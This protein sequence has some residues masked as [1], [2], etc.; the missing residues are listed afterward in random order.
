MS[1]NFPLTFLLQVKNEMAS[2]LS[3]ATSQMK[4]MGEAA[5]SS[6]ASVKQSGI[7]IGA[8]LS[9]ITMNLVNTANQIIGLKRQWEDLTRMQNNVVQSDNSLLNAKGKLKIAT[10]NLAQAQAGKGKASAIDLDIAHRSLTA[11][12]NKYGKGSI[13]AE[14]AQSALNKTQ[15]KGG[16]DADTITKK[17][18][19][20]DRAVRGVTSAVINDKE[21]HVNLQRAYE[22]FYLQIIPT[23]IGVVGSFASVL[24]VVQKSG[25]GFASSIGK[26]ILPLAGIG[27][28]FLAIQTNF[29][30]FRDMLQG[31]GKTI[32]DALPGLKPFLQILED[33]GG[34][35]GLTPKK[36]NLNQHIKDL[37]KSIQPFIDTFKGVIDSIMKGDWSGAFKKIKDAAV[38]FWNDLVASVPFFAGVNALVGMIKQGKWGEAFDF[39]KRAALKFWADLKTA[40]PF[41]ADVETFITS[42]SKGEW[43][44]AFKAVMQGWQDSGIPVGIELLF[45]K[46]WKSGIDAA[47]A[48]FFAEARNKSA[49]PTGVILQALVTINAAIKAV[50]GIDIA[51]YFKAHPITID[52]I[53][54]AGVVINATIKNVTGVDMV[55]WWKDHPVTTAIPMF[56]GITMMVD[57][58]EYRASIVKGLNVLGVAMADLATTLDPH[59]ADMINNID[60]TGGDWA[61]A[62]QDMWDQL[63]KGLNTSASKAD[64]QKL[65][66]DA[67]VAVFKSKTAG[68]VKGALKETPLGQGL[69]GLG[70]G[71]P[72]TQEQI[73]NLAK[74]GPFDIARQNGIELNPIILAQQ[75]F[76]YLS[77]LWSP[78]TAAG[79]Q[80]PTGSKKG[81]PGRMS[82][83]D[84]LSSQPSTIPKA[85]YV[86]PAPDMGKFYAAIDTGVK[87][88]QDLG[89]IVSSAVLALPGVNTIKFTGS[90]DSAVLRVQGLASIVA[91][92]VIALPGVNTIKFTGSIDSAVK[93]VQDLAGIVASTKIA[94][95]GVNMIK[96]FG[97]IDSGVKRVQSLVQIIATTQFNIPGVNLTKFFNSMDIMVRR[98]QGVQT[99]IN[100]LHGKNVVNTITTVHRTVY[101]AKGFH[102]M[103]SGP[104]N[105]MA[106]EKGKEWVDVT[107]MSGGT[108]QSA[109]H[110]PGGGGPR[111]RG[112]SGSNMP[113][114]IQLVVDGRVLAEVVQGKMTSKQGAY[115]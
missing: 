68:A 65:I 91:S 94:L 109:L 61:K 20:Y 81:K 54:Q 95:P 49:G 70:L 66:A 7:S 48:L 104:T 15:A 27:L 44:K 26:M 86:M 64:W 36:E 14:K 51:A 77:K 16:K 6:G 19:A 24:Q 33:I 78:Q 71:E 28:A 18:V 75:A 17:Q 72:K 114:I 87:R 22:D 37:M 41:L 113:Q 63:W 53:V 108:S 56:G 89:G 88:I 57:D 4:S 9:L 23:A 92:T 2:G 62:A 39:I 110:S 35:L 111:G 45:G 5:K 1:D 32:G 12:Q 102:G 30:G 79:A 115:K 106:G 11:A 96:F 103:V 47:I 85:P 60:F 43:S 90:I 76:D 3:Q 80:M 58:P 93:R 99:I 13:Q 73:N 67:I 42:L 25:I 31:L 38:K 101:A 74:G 112:G 83:A 50:T 8:G 98:V 105:F 69:T 10:L 100:S 82:E 46:N 59:I 29:L 34:I 107:P 40:V 21:A 97:S 84:W 52:A 55:K